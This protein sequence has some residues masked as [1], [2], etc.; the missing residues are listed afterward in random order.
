MGQQVFLRWGNGLFGAPWWRPGGG[1]LLFRVK[2]LGIGW[3]HIPLPKE[4]LENLELGP[5]RILTPLS[6]QGFSEVGTGAEGF[7][8]VSLIIRHFYLPLKCGG[9]GPSHVGFPNQDTAPP[10]PFQPTVKRSW[11]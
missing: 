11:A 1:A 7:S 5:H 10:Q 2:V 6:Q 9:C 3:G 8:S 4:T